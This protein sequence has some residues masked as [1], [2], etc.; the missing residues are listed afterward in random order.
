MPYVIVAYD[1]SDDN[2]RVRASEKLISM[3]YTRLQ[4][5]FYIRRGGMSEAKETFRALSRIVNHKTDNL[6]VAVVPYESIEKAF[7]INSGVM[8]DESRGYYIL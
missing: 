6:I 8:F 5:S 4:R 2:R 1:I 3:G 7:R